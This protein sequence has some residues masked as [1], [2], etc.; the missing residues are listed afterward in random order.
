MRS[1]VLVHL[2]DIHYTDK[3]ENN[4]LFDNLVS[5]LK[6]KVS[7]WTNRFGG[8]VITG[9]VVNKGQVLEFKKF[10]KKLD[11][12][13]KEIKVSE[14][15]TLVVAGNHDYDRNGKKLRKIKAILSAKEKSKDEKAAA[16][17][18]AKKRKASNETADSIEFNDYLECFGEY[19]TFVSENTAGNAPVIYKTIQDVT[20]RFVCINSSWST[21]I[22]KEYEQLLIDEEQIKQIKTIVN[23]NRQRRCDL[24]IVLMHHPLDWF[25]FESRKRL[26]DLFRS[27]KADIFLHGHVHE[28]YAQEQ[29]DIDEA[30]VSLCTGVSYHK[31]G[32]NC[33]RKDGMR[34]SVYEINL[35]TKTINVFGRS[36]G[37]DGWFTF[38]NRLYKNTEGSEFFTLPFGGILECTFPLY[39]ASKADS[40]RNKV[41]LTRDFFDN[42][43]KNE[44]KL[45][46]LQKTVESLCNLKFCEKEYAQ[47][48]L[49]ANGGKS[50]D[51]PTASEA[52]TK[53]KYVERVFRMFFET[54][55]DGIK[56]LFQDFTKV[57]VMLRRYNPETKKHEC[58][59]AIGIKSGDEEQKQIKNFEWP[60][61]MVSKSFSERRALLWSTNKRFSEKGN[62]PNRWKEYLT[63]TIPSILFK[64]NKS[65]PYYS[66]NIAT[67]SF[68]NEKDFIC[69]SLSSLYDKIDDFFS[70]YDDKSKLFMSQM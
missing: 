25:E 32:E 39:S 3:D 6:T 49:D 15:N 31:A 5:D 33:S 19:N 54:I 27:L 37:N 45:S 65:I 14:D 36:T 42:F 62:H 29:L 22:G 69:L 66:L 12:L 56:S 58:L 11:E 55:A 68:C 38:D 60:R 9:D 2:S 4:I 61:G 57:R 53:E 48:A 7:K 20:I 64:D 52:T 47:W 43:R 41:F 16:D 59:Y 8:I 70:L 18:G 10:E 1:V 40:E 46:H 30:L 51:T 24:T 23:N 13:R 44:K 67:N 35:D 28:S 26:K 21:M 50:T 63:I 17:N 34:Y